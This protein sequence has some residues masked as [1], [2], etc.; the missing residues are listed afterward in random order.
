MN[1][2]DFITLLGGATFPW[3]LVARAQQPPMPIVGFLHSGS[4][5]PMA[6]ILTGFRL[7]LRD[8]GYVEGQNV[9]V[10]YRWARG[11]YDQLPALAAVLVK[12][13]VSVIAAGGGEVTA[14]AVKMETSTIPVVFALASDPVKAG[15]AESLNRPGGNFTGV[16][17]LTSD[18]ETKK[19]GLLRETVPHTAV[20]AMLINPNY[21]P[22][23]LAAMEVQTAAHSLLQRLV[24]L[25]ASSEQDI[26]SV[27]ATLV[28]Q[29]VGAL[30]VAGDPFFN[31]HRE[32]LVA[33][34]AR[35]AL[36][37]IYEFREYA[38]AGGLMSY[39]IDLPDNY[40]Q[41]GNYVG[42]I[43]K[44]VKPA[45]LPIMQAA[46]FEFVIN[47]KTAKDLGLT[48][49]SGVLAIADEVIE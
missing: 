17:S 46:K 21:P 39:G 42:R 35:H 47:L 33:L 26:E 20:I 5:E 41:M 1:R 34:A 25:R 10:E 45:E 49:P 14:Q 23:E 38:L 27:F 2:R 6:H 12:Q 37:A 19:F 9:A 7:G 43:L 29:Q 31:S 4:P 13:G 24:V 18:V 36:P 22:D 40:R 11:H 32:L 48:I 44:D 30:L 3:P 16:I 15:L 8:T 28:E